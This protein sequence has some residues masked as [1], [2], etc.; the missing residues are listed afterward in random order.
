MKLSKLYKI[1]KNVD[2]RFFKGKFFGKMDALAYRH[3]K[4]HY[5]PTIYDYLKKTK[6]PIDTGDG[7]II[8][9]ADT[10]MSVKD[11]ILMQYNSPFLRLTDGR[12][13]IPH[14]FLYGND[15]D[16]KSDNIVINVRQ[17][18]L[19]LDSADNLVS[20][21]K[22][23]QELVK[24]R[25]NYIQQTHLFKYIDGTNVMYR[26]S[27]AKEEQG[28]L[29]KALLQIIDSCKSSY[30]IILW[31]S[32]KHIW[33]D[34]QNEIIANDHIKICGV[35]DYVYTD[36]ELGGFI[37]GAYH[38]AVMSPK[39]VD[40]KKKIIIDSTNH[41]DNTY[42]TRILD[43]E[44]E[45]PYYVI[46]PRDAQ[47]TS[48]LFG[49]LKR[50]I[51]AKHSKDI[52]I[53]KYDNILHSTD[54]YIQNE[55]MSKLLSIDT[56]I[57]Q[58]YEMLNNCGANVALIKRTK[59]Y[60][61]APN[62]AALNNRIVL[63]KDIDFLTTDCEIETVLSIVEEF[64][65]SHFKGDRIKVEEEVVHFNHGSKC[66]KFLWVRLMDFNV[67]LFHIQTR[68]YD[69]QPEFLSEALSHKRLDGVQQV[70]DDPEYEIYMRIA[71]LLEHPNKQH[72]IEYVQY[73]KDRI[74]KQSILKA[75]GNEN[76]SKVTNLLYSIK[77]E[78]K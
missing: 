15:E 51:R 78:L 76:I 77:I 57:S 58:L 55:F 54:N 27:Y 52:Q 24:V 74:T 47:P 28:L 43:V 33:E 71:E 31:S 37:E 45:N 19:L 26:T 73:Y 36:E 25:V 62:N 22:R 18:G 23:G 4:E 50:N 72:H 56:N 65:K 69:L 49:E 75:F 39:G 29:D 67:V 30:K 35:K 5:P 17:D 10:T 1:F 46:D 68:L 14:A 48:Q 44:V 32:A 7:L 9:V 53:Y 66:N 42:A 2:K 34:L 61:P 6:Q 3:V 60:N 59:H 21:L 16:K 8:Y 63:S 11:I 64:A 13:D 41:I 20:L 40:Y 38:F 12:Y 70:I